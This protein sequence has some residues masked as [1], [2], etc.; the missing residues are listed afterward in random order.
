MMNLFKAILFFN[1]FPVFV[2]SQQ[3]ENKYENNK[4]YTHPEVIEAYLA[5][6]NQSQLISID[7]FGI[8][9]AGIPLHVV[10]IANNHSAN[11]LKMLV[12]NGIHPGESCGIDASLHWV[13]ELIKNPDRLKNT[14]VYI[15]PIY[16]VGGSLNRSCCTRANQNGPDNQGFRG[17]AQNLDLNRDF[18]KADSKN[19]KSL[20]KLFTKID[21][22]V[23]VDTHSTNGAD[24][25]YAMTLIPYQHEKYP[26]PVEKI[27]RHWF[28][29][30]LEET[31][32]KVKTQY[33]VNVWGTT[34]D[35]GFSAFQVTS[36]FSTGYTGLF[37]TFAITTEAHMF[38]PYAER[39]EA[40]MV[41][42]DAILKISTANSKKIKDA[43]NTLKNTI[44]P[45]YYATRWVLD[46]TSRQKID[47]LGYEAEFY[48]SELTGQKAYRYNREK[49]IEYKTDFYGLFKP[50]DSVKIPKAY[51]LHAGQHKMAKHLI[52]NG[53]TVKKL[54]KDT[55]IQ[56]GVYHV[57][58]IEYATR[59]YEGHFP[60]RNFALEEKLTVE[61]FLAG[62][63]II[64]PEG[65]A[66]YYAIEALEP[67]SPGSF[68]RWN[69]M[70]AF[71]QQKEG[72]SAYIFEEM[73]VKFL[74]ENPQIKANFET[75]KLEDKD[76]A[77]SGY[78]QLY[79]IYQQTPYYEKEFMRIP[80]F[81]VYE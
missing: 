73:A 79:W 19:A 8:T 67:E 64:I 17:N 56:G 81:K 24:Y 3:L 72:F 71:L 53:V 15:V 36:I 4:T 59:P 58:N 23:F 62:D 34:P 48:T 68:F 51:F 37:G 46:S 10:K 45:K 54:K 57:V 38:K 26:Q 12:I 6:S 65:R 60:H 55:L 78:A 5:L 22:D 63:F 61:K 11:N 32:K 7:T 42:L 28:D 18:M 40:T 39:V 77:K 25:Q 35:K 1:C 31:N 43:R 33:Y 50:T 27:S 41:S 21:P 70:D 30:I 66:K 20:H 75:K 76:F 47:F 2:F 80:I 69:F 44:K 52:R 14:A 13:E 9:D 16:N 29:Q 74:N 49:P